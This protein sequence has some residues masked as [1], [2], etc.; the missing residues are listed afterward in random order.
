MAQS[1]AGVESISI[2]AGHLDLMLHIWASTFANSQDEDGNIIPKGGQAAALQQSEEIAASVPP[3]Q[4]L[5]VSKARVKDCWSL[6]T[7]LAGFGTEGVPQLVAATMQH[8]E[9]LNAGMPFPSGAG[10]HLVSLS[11]VMP[12][13]HKVFQLW[14][15]FMAASLNG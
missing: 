14:L 2:F 11:N 12:A 9:R 1:V 3:A 15:A 5:Q 10:A 6:I 4:E 8:A 13:W 7:A